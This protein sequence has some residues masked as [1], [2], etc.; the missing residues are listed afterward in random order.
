MDGQHV[1]QLAWGIAFAGLMYVIGN[2]VWI[3]HLARRRQW[4]GWLLWSITALIVIVVGALIDI[5][6]AGD[7]NGLWSHLTSVDKENHW[8]VLTLFALMSV[9][10]A[11]SIIFR[12]D[13]NWTRLA[14]ILPAIVVFIPTGM[15]LG[16]GVI[17]GLGVALAVCALTG[18]WQVLLDAEPVTKKGKP[19]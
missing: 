4:M 17:A 2:G 19:A 9:P 13:A 11:A 16:Q 3:N 12:L 7:T 5:R 10:G 18:G 8:I 1:E 14:L 15:Q 6:L